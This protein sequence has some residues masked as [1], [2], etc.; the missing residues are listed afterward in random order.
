MEK[1][2]L[3]MV[4]KMK[5]VLVIVM[6]LKMMK[7]LDLLRR[8]TSMDWLM[9]MLPKLAVMRM[10]WRRRRRSTCRDGLEF[11]ECVFG[12]SMAWSLCTVAWGDVF[13]LTKCRPG[14]IGQRRLQKGAL[15]HFKKTL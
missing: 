10:N 14:K 4:K 6:K 8:T 7:I 2:T 12:C 13:H 3:R 5:M 1:Y 9:K 11:V 15:L